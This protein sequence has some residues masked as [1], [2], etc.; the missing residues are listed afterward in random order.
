M[1]DET[2]EERKTLLGFVASVGLLILLSAVAI[3]LPSGT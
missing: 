1:T 3:L 2:M